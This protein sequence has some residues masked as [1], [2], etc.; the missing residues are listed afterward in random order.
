M[1][2]SYFIIILIPHHFQFF[3]LFCSYSHHV[4]L[5]SRNWMTQPCMKYSSN[6]LIII[7]IGATTYVFSLSGAGTATIYI[8]YDNQLYF[9]DLCTWLLILCYCGFS[10]EAVSKEKKLL[11]VSLYLLIWGEASN[12]RF[13][14]ECLCYIF[15]HVS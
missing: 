8:M 2:I 15:H 5:V 14:P 1:I 11:Y 12:V 6:P 3:V 10:L 9:C 7:L 13:L 4:Y